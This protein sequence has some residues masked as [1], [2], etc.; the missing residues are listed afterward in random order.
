MDIIL[1]MD[2]M[3]Q[4]MVVLDIFDRVVEINSPTVEHTT[5]YLPFKDGT[6]SCAYVKDRLGDQRGGGVNGSR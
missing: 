1:V 2:W 5:L 3:T 4:H 6:N